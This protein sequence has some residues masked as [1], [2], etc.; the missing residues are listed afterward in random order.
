VIEFPPE[1]RIIPGVGA[2][3]QALRRARNRAIAE[4]AAALRKLPPDQRDVARLGLGAGLMFRAIKAS[5]EEGIIIGKVSVAGNF[6][7]ENERVQLA[8]LKAATYKL[9][10]DIGTTKAD[11]SPAV[12]VDLCHDKT[13]KAEV[14]MAWTGHA[15]DDPNAC[16]VAIRPADRSIYDDAKAGKII[17]MSFAGPYTLSAAKAGARHN[18]ADLENVQKAHLQVTLAYAAFR[19]GDSA[20]LGAALTAALAATT[21]LVPEEEA[22][23]AATKASWERTKPL[24]SAEQNARALATVR[25]EAQPIATGSAP[26]KR[27]FFDEIKEL[28]HVDASPQLV[29]HT[30][31]LE[32]IPNRARPFGEPPR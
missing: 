11:G 16:Y 28:V 26:P 19:A 25:G 18:S 10:R 14:L 30:T 9:V 24:V 3:E 29:R 15:L 22:E 12:T 13:I 7:R 1:L 27:N 6:D 32:A 20:K 4:K 2:R 31:M 8:A 17:G 21:A 5:D 23:T